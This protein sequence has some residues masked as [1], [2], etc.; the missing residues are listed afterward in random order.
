M[1][2]WPATAAVITAWVAVCGCSINHSAAP[3]GVSGT[4]GATAPQSVGSAASNAAAASPAAGSG[5]GPVASAAGGPVGTPIA[6]GSAA[7]GGRSAALDAGHGARADA[8]AGAGSLSGAIVP[9]VGGAAG[10]VGSSN[11]AGAA[12]VTGALAPIAAPTPDDCITDVKP[13]DHTYQC[14]GHT[15]LTMVDEQCTKLACGLIFDVH[16]ASMSGPIMRANTQLHQLAPSKG[17]IVVHPS[18]NGATGYDGTWDLAKDPPLLAD[19]MT[20]VINAFHVDTKRVHITGFSMGSA[21]TFWFLCNHRDVLASAAPVTGASA[22]QVN[23]VDT[24]MPCIASIDAN[25]KPRVPILFMSGS[26]DNALSIDAARARTEGIVMRL[27]LTGGTQ[28]AG[29]DSYT[30]KHWQAADGMVFEFIEHKYANALLGGHCVPGGP[31]D[32]LIAC[33][34]GGSTLHWGKT[35]LQWMIEHPKP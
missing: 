30:R 5:T 16:G 32:N 13:G 23:V 19:F 2:A 25:W 4:A 22:E 34:D 18:A 28:I 11:A 3:Q 29:D 20:R 35:V 1:Q 12:G 33:T 8:G 6:A 31:A 14:Q 10:A 17:Y 9:S 27:G 15:F 26:M 24:G 7:N 21:M